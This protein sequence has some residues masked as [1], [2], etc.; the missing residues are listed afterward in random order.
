[1]LIYAYGCLKKLKIN[2]SQL[3]P[4][5]IR[6]FEINLLQRKSK[7]FELNNEEL[8]GIDDLL[9]ESSREFKMIINKKNSKEYKAGDF[10]LTLNPLSCNICNFKE[11]CSKHLKYGDDCY[12]PDIYELFQDF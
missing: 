12:E 7:E 10:A 4:D 8:Y 2:N 1:M 9:F 3:F 11:L 5:D 6:L